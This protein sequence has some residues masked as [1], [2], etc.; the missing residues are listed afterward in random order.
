METFLISSVVVAL[1]ELGDKTQFLALLLAA[2]YRKPVLLCVALLVATLAS[3][4]LGGALAFVMTQ[5]MKPDA[6]KWV[7]CVS[8]VGLAGWALTAETC[9]E[10]AEDTAR[11]GVFGAV[12]L[13]FFLVQFG[14]KAQVATVV[15]AAQSKAFLP[16]L[17]GTTLGALVANLPA[18][19]IGDRWAAKLPV[20]AMHWL[21]AAAFAA[22]AVL[23]FLGNG[24]RFGF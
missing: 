8:F 9:E 11:F 14:G 4:A 10:K 3:N 21:A 7:V 13:A 12:T 1:T 19:I 2:K 17:A 16:V 20:D 24:A 18:L 23:S 6:L 5:F 15:M 22:L